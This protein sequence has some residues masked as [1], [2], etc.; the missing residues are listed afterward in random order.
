MTRFIAAAAGGAILG[1]LAVLWL[2]DT[3]DRPDD[4]TVVRDIVAVPAMSEQ[5]AAAHREGRYAELDTVAAVYALPG[6]FA[7]AEA[8]H[9]LAGRTDAAGAQKLIFEANRIAEDL[10]RLD[11]LRILFARLAELDP[12]S[13]LALARTEYFRGAGLLEQ[14]V[15]RAWGRMNL[16]DALFAAKTQ[17]TRTDRNM[18][19]QGL[20]AAFDYMGN[21]TTERIEAELGVGPDRA[22]RS[23]YLYLLADRSPGDAV[24]FIESAPQGRQRG[25]YIWWLAYYLSLRDPVAA[26]AA[27]DLFEQPSDAEQ[28]RNHVRSSEARAQPREVIDRILASGN[29]AR[30][31]GE[32][33]SAIRTL[34]ST[35]LDAAL[36]YFDQARSIEEK[37]MIGSAVAAE[38]VSRD[39][40]EAL[41]W[42]RTNDAGSS[43]PRLEMSVL[44]AIA[45]TDP[46]YAL[47]E[48]QSSDSAEI[49]QNLLTNLVSRLA[50]SEPHDAI[51]YMELIED[52]ALR[53]QTESQLVSS[54]M[55]NDPDAALDW[56]LGQDDEAVS[57]LLDQSAWALIRTDIDAAIRV[58]PRLTDEQQQQWRLQ[59][60]HRLAETR[61]EDAQAFVGRFE[62][63][64]GYDQMQAS[65][66]AA[67]A[68]KDAA[69]ARQMAD[70]ISNPKA[71][72]SAYAAIAG[73]TANKDPRAAIAMLSSIRDAHYRGMATAQVANNWHARDPGAADRWVASL[74]A[75][76][77]RDDAIMHLA[78]RW[79]R[80]G[81]EQR[82]LIDSIADEHKRGQAKL[83]LVYNLMRTD[84][85][86]ART[87]L[88]DPDIPSYQRQQVETM[89][90]SGAVRF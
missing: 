24:A 72:D 25:E 69:Q 83:R 62:G 45:E 20:F 54:W 8:L 58:L 6:D 5:E 47:T 80:P 36:A 46:Q 43:Y 19:A 57:R 85:A 87:L 77:V 11:A 60:T 23:R 26:L 90:K 52:Q 7:R 50:R 37:Q 16:E 22:T 18:A 78:M 21:Q 44:S 48:A 31:R 66:I 15:W 49:R 35:D 75:G 86:A 29:F 76:S 4:R 53:Q 82:A 89:I 70:Q 51:A 27:A 32:F 67:I 30:S 17:T 2:V 38:L 79:Q 55:R 61:P 13:A 3:R 41:T 73:E 65:L 14:T 34:A 63:K 9:A 64:P 71:R 56:V 39:P 10:V 68:S 33:A 28:F 84:P 1:A 59:I 42:A 74:P 81:A 88:E 40:V 12:P